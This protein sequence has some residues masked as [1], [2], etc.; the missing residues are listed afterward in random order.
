MKNF[1]VHEAGVGVQAKN[2]N[3]IDTTCVNIFI[4]IKFKF[5]WNQASSRNLRLGLLRYIHTKNET[6]LS[7]F[8]DNIFKS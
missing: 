8:K 3:V 1:A 5:L 7:I 2:I 4:D 6:F